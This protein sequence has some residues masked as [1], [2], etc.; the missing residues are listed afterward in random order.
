MD[1]QHQLPERDKEQKDKLAQAEKLAGEQ[2]RRASLLRMT[3][4]VLGVLL[5]QALGVATQNFRE[6]PTTVAML[7]REPGHPDSTP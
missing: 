1:E 5:L 2:S 4:L 3:V 7:L 6:A